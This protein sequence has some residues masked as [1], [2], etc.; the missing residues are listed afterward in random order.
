M[1]HVRMYRPGVDPSSVLASPV[2]MRRKGVEN[3]GVQFRSGRG[4]R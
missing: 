4:D 3:G 2:G 1:V